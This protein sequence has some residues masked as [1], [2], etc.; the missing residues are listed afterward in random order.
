[1]TAER[2]HQIGGLFDRLIE[3]PPAERQAFLH[4]A[5]NGD[6]ELRW[7]LES[8][9]ECD[10]PQQRLVE[11]P[12]ER[13]DAEPDM[14]GRRVGPYQL[15]RLIGHGGM[16]SVYLG[17]RNDDQ[18]QKQVAV[19]LLSRGMATA[20]MLGRFRQE[21]QILA[22]LEH[23]FIARLLDGGATEDGLPYF[24]MEYVD[25]VSITQYCAEKGLSLGER[26]RLFRLVCEAVQHAHQHL[27]IHRDIKPGNILTTKE[28]VP[29][30]L[31]FGIA[32]VLDPAM[33]RDLTV[34][35]AEFRMMTPEYASPE[36][37]KGLPIST[38]SDVYSLGAVLYELLT[39]RSPHQ[40]SSGSVAE[41]EKAICETEPDRP[42]TVVG[43]RAELA[44][45]VRKKSRRELQ[46]DLDNIVLTALWKEPQRRYASVAALSEDL[47]RHMEA[48]PILAQAERL[49]SRVSKFV[50]RHKA[51]VVAST[52]VVASLI[53]G[54]V[55][56][57]FQA[58]RAE[59]R[60]EMVRGLANDMLF[61]LYDQM[62]RL[63]GS[64]GLRAATLGT[65]VS[66]LDTLAR[67]GSPAPRLE[68]EI[69]K[70]YERA[71]NIEG[72]P[73]KSNLGRGQAALSNYR[74]ALAIYER[75]EHRRDLG[76]DVIR[77][78]IE[79]HIKVSGMEAFLGNP[80]AARTHWQSASAIASKALASGDPEIPKSTQ[81][82]LYFR[83]ADVEYD[84][85]IAGGELAYYRKA[86]EVSQGW[87]A[88]ARSPEALAYLREA[89]RNVGSAMARG[90]DLAGAQESYGRTRE[91]AE[92]LLHRPD[93]AVDQ[94]Y[95][96][97]GVYNSLGDV[98]AAS[99]DPNLGDRAHAL[100][101]YQTALAM[102]QR[103]AASEPENVNARRY[104]AAC[105]QRMGMYWAEENPSL[106]LRY[107]QAALKIAE[108][109]S[110]ADPLNAE[111]RYHASRAYM[112]LGDAL[113]NLGRHDDAAENL[114][115][116]VEIQ[117]AIAAVSPERIWNLRVLS[118]THAI[119]GRALLGAGD[120]DRALSVLNDGLAI[121]D[122]M[123][124]R[125]PSS[126]S[127]Q[128]DRADLLEALGGHYAA[129]ARK[130]GLESARRAIWQADARA[131]YQRSSAIWKYW[132][133]RK[134]A[135]PYAK[136]RLNR[137]DS[138]LRLL[139]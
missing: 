77:G 101:N 97:I 99:D 17:V 15:L 79:M 50:R 31:D 56:S 43:R 55:S 19:K 70:A 25:G 13:Q 38:A 36:Q 115:R 27:V 60:F 21:R 86:L 33:S 98:Q 53:G 107:F 32:K 29:K 80:A 46:G 104:V 114:R 138:A 120:P 122:R 54:I 131:Y 61:G 103:L 129:L 49:S 47:R 12:V 14:S 58:R 76:S 75:L 85:G 94:Q 117:K 30:L 59:R 83:L 113:H 73:M 121:A 89:H 63:P 9:L 22:N 41:M 74:K 128:L 57:T 69:A 78:L 133:A 134:L 93:V 112:G 96:T 51:A 111:Y 108:A 28:G 52:L 87:V 130:P 139:P 26:V 37:I 100:E 132:N 4:H 72:H 35:R 118:R 3:C 40:F 11:L 62:E 65:V 102:A 88:A 90:G 39:G 1:M 125:A 24:V 68:I 5:C 7:E 126:L 105:N 44:A 91:V 124:Q 16:G 123:L 106:A 81:I 82:N 18:Y 136:R 20:F 119:L 92:E 67:D 34:T 48:L 45:N 135:A 6:D 84:R 66:Y 2:W 95:N 127:H 116:S 8:L 137:V 42:S 23:P 109:L 71:G 110:A 10:A 64:T